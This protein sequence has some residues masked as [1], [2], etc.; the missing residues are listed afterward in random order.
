M[1]AAVS[2]PTSMASKWPALITRVEMCVGPSRA[3]P[4]RTDRVVVLGTIARCII[5]VGERHV[6]RSRP[7]TSL[8]RWLGRDG[9][10]ESL[11]LYGGV[12]SSSTSTV[13]FHSIPFIPRHVSWSSAAIG[14]HSRANSSPRTVK[15]SLPQW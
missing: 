12:P 14:N 3:G 9:L 10:I 7:L 13:P 8:A 2:P 4:G 15:M 1:P 5:D 6:Q 11:A